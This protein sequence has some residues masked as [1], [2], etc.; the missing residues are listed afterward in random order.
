M[1]PV[2]PALVKDVLALSPVDRSAA[3]SGRP[4]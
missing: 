2:Y 3:D 1:P 4:C